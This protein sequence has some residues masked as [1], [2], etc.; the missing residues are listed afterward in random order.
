MAS[1][2]I[3]VCYG[4]ISL[5]FPWR[6]DPRVSL[7]F[8]SLISCLGLQKEGSQE[9]ISNVHYM[10]IAHNRYH[11]NLGWTLYRCLTITS[12]TKLCIAFIF[13]YVTHQTIIAP[14][15]YQK[16]L[17]TVD[18]WLVYRL[19]GLWYSQEKISRSWHGHLSHQ[20]LVLSVQKPWW[21]GNRLNSGMCQNWLRCVVCSL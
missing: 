13:S 8:N 12:Q 19:L 3:H 2:N 15:C 9:L 4:L 16:L 10:D 20:M 14:S 11:G 17:L 21:A 7:N 5:I 6:N 1:R 18:L